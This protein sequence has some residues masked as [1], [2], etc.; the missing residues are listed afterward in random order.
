MFSVVQAIIETTDVKKSPLADT[1]DNKLF[2]RTC[3]QCHILF[4][5]PFNQRRHMKRIHAEKEIDLAASPQPK[6]DSTNRKKSANGSRENRLFCPMCT[7]SD[8]SFSTPFNLKRHQKRVHPDKEL[9]SSAASQS[10]TETSAA[11][12][13]EN[14]LFC[15]LG[16]DCNVSFSTPSTLRRHMRRF[17]QQTESSITAIQEPIVDTVEIK[18]CPLCD[19][20]ENRLN[21][22]VHFN[23]VHGLQVIIEYQLFDSEAQLDEWLSQIDIEAQFVVRKSDSDRT[24]ISCSQPNGSENFCPAEMII[25]NESGKCTVH[26]VKTHVHE[27]W[28]IAFSMDPSS[29]KI[30]HFLC[31]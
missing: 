26:Y 20:R 1:P 30:I 10:V 4:S 25:L 7:E 22:Y 27:S 16:T 15:P 3:Q 12:S 2:S 8:V 6:A 17:H 21:L 18:K 11:D 24:I 5:S 9:D 19:Y 29:E 31:N 28:E 13:P 23:L 14:L